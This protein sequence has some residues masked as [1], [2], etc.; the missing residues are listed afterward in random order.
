MY[1]YAPVGKAEQIVKAVNDMGYPAMVLKQDKGV[2][3][4]DC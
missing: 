3:I 1:C 4:T 2:T